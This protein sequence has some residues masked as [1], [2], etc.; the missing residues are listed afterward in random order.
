[1]DY[2]QIPVP[3]GIDDAA[4]KDLTA[5]LT[6]QVQQFTQTNTLECE[7]DPEWRAETLKSIQAGIEDADAGRVLDHD[8]ALQ[9]TRNYAAR[10]RAE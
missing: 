9:R 1:M 2:L 5:W 10:S 7:N 8:Q 4:K 3:D 6:K